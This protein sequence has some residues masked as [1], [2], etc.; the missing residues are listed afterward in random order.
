MW[1]NIIITSRTRRDLRH[2]KNPLTHKKSAPRHASIALPV[3]CGKIGIVNQVVLC[4]LTHY[5]GNYFNTQT[6]QIYLRQILISKI[7]RARA[8]SVE[9]ATLARRRFNRVESWRGSG[10]GV[11]RAGVP[12]WSESE[13]H[14]LPIKMDIIGFFSGARMIVKN[15]LFIILVQSLVR[16]LACY[17]DSSANRGDFG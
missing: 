11:R 13:H 2:N 9:S 17:I 12:W 8:G 4:F 1:F 16:G 6:L 15:L 7:L 10:N 14:K 5:N 3:E